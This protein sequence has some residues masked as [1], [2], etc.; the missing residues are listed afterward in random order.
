[1]RVNVDSLS[2]AI[3]E[4]ELLSGHLPLALRNFWTIH[5]KDETV[6]STRSR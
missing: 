1:M 3:E 5:A 4:N 2:A 6:G